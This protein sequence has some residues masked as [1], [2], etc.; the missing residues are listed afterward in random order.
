MGNP[1][2]SIIIP[3]YNHEQ[4]IGE[5]ITSVL[6]QT[7]NDFELI[8]I[9]DCS[10]DNSV[11]EIEKFKDQRIK[12][13]KND[14]NMGAVLTTNF[15][16]SLCQGEY[17]AILNS[18]DSWVN[19]K[20]ELQVKVLDTMKEVGAVFSDVKFIN[21]NNIELNSSTYQWADVFKQENRSHSL[22]LRRFFFEFNCLC[23]PSILIR[24]KIYKETN[25]YN[26]ALRQLPD[27]FMW[28]QI[29]K[30]TEI[31]ILPDKL[32]L[33]K[34]LSNNQN[35]SA[36]TIVNKNR[37]RNEIYLVMKDFFDG[38]D[39]KTFLEGFGDLIKKKNKEL[40]VDEIKCEQAFMFLNMNSEVDY[41][42]RLIA[43]EQ[44]YKLLANHDTRDVLKN[45]YNFSD[46]DYFQM[47]GEFGF[48]DLKQ[49]NL[50]TIVVENTKKHFENKP[51]YY[52]LLRK[53]YRKFKNK[54]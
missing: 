23:H 1:K 25:L 8:I 29:L 49:N 45:E 53:I 41:I 46:K 3:S 22:W 42:Y 15:G 16:I 40:T 4:Y 9:D 17:I 34:I 21:E 19:E 5:C 26:P 31:Y 14:V 51:T 2:V 10:K 27:F 44:F 33:F 6:N 35:A 47:T 37:T 7:F 54:R 28:V 50:S 52:T 43:M 20:L 36:D 32:V 38:M 18:D 30:F 11:K 24:S 13:Y 48:I 39:S 12:F